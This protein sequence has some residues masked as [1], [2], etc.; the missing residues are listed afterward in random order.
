VATAAP[1][2]A[3]GAVGQGVEPPAFGP[4]FAR[5]VFWLLAVGFALTGMAITAVTVHLI[6]IIE[7][8]SA[9]APPQIAAML[10]G[11]AQV[12]VR[13]LDATLWRHQHPLWVAILSSA[14][15]CL[16]LGLTFLPGAA[17]VA[18]LVFPVALGAGAGLGS[19]V[20]G[21]VPAA[22]F[23]ARG[24]GR[25][26]GQLTAVRNALGAVAPFLF[27]WA[28]M[29]LSPAGAMAATGVVAVAGLI[30]LIALHQMLTGRGHLP[31]AAGSGQS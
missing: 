3:S 17:L 31:K 14:L 27:A 8:L 24:L 29:A 26:L 25:R 21:A 11:P 10:M 7:S 12:A 22:L 30:A 18:A 28:S 1:E 16:A 20:R 4:A 23:G 6:A 15:I 2:T 5:R 13:V 9:G 19:I